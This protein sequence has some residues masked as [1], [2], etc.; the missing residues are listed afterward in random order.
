M[1]ALVGLPALRIRGIYLLLATLGFHY[2][3]GFLFLKYQIKWFGFGSVDYLEPA[4][5][6]GLALDTEIRWYYFLLGFAVFWFAVTKN[7]LRTRQGRSLV[8]VRDHEI[9]A[10]MAGI[11]VAYARIMSFS[12]SSFMITAAGADLRVVPRLGRGGHLHAAVRDRLHRHDRD[13]RRGLA[14]RHGARGDRLAV[15]ADRARGGS[16]DVG[17]RLARRRRTGSRSGRPS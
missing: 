5:L 15:H 9:A 11:N 2:V 14:H 17:R 4:T 6:F 1:G 10:S 12:V 7:L 3:M 16:R 8:A 13:R